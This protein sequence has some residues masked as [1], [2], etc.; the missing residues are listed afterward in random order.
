[1]KRNKKIFNPKVEANIVKFLTILV[2]VQFVIYM[3]IA[4]VT[5]NPDYFMASFGFT[6][7]IAII[8]LVFALINEL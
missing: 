2:V 4:C 1:M 6:L 3:G 8:T 7:I 5:D